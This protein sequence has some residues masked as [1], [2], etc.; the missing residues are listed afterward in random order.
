MLGNHPGGGDYFGAGSEAASHLPPASS[1]SA[2]TSGPGM[3]SGRKDLTYYIARYSYFMDVFTSPAEKKGPGR[4]RAQ[5]FANKGL[6]L[7][8]QNV[9]RSNVQLFLHNNLFRVRCNMHFSIYSI[10]T[11]S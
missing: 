5:Q 3:Q 1:S 8:R 7:Y 10:I 9:F 2:V 11:N 6:S 4:G